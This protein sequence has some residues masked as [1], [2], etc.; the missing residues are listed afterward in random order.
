MTY[1]IIDSIILMLQ[2][3]VITFDGLI[4]FVFIRNKQL[5]RNIAHRLTLFVATTDFLH[6]FTTLPYT[7]YLTIFCATEPVNLEPYYIMISSTP[8]IIQMKVKLTLTAAIALQRTMALFFPIS[9]RSSSSTLFTSISLLLGVSLACGD[10][11]LEFILSPIKSSPGCG[12]IGCFVS[13]QFLFYWGTS[14]MVLG[15]VVVIFTFMILFK[16]HSIEKKQS[17]NKY[18]NREANG[19]NQANRTTAGILL[20]TLF[21][22]TLPSVGVGIMEMV[23]FSIFRRVGPFYSTGLLCAG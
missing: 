12:T 4:L 9:Y 14:N 10:L 15:I 1:L 22:L 5:Y 11:F 2:L 16:L 23:G 18:S 21:F 3:A 19:Y 17:G 7:I 8:L 13:D 6:A 20:T